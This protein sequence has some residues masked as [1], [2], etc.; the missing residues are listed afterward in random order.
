MQHG[1]RSEIKLVAP[2]FTPE[3]I[4]PQHTKIQATTGPSCDTAAVAT[5]AFKN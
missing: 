2:E 4:A 3:T 1:D 5:R